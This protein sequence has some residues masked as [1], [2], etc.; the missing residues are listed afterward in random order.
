[1]ILQHFSPI[2]F[3]FEC[4]YY[5]LSEFLLFHQYLREIGL[6]LTSVENGHSTAGEWKIIQFSNGKISGQKKKW[7]NLMLF[8]PFRSRI[9]TGFDKILIMFILIPLFLRFLKTNNCFLLPSKT[10]WWNKRLDCLRGEVRR[11]FNL[12]KSKFYNHQTSKRQHQTK[13]ITLHAKIH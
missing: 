1:M 11:L 4:T 6:G 12:A 2:S 8:E 13:E 10:V 3:H 5:D 7:M 9:K